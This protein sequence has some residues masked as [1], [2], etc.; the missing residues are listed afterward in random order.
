MFLHVLF[1]KNIKGHNA[2][3]GCDKCVQNCVCEE[4]VTFPEIASPFRTDTDFD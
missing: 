3:H 4:K 2:Y 1:F